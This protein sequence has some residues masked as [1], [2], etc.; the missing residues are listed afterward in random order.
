MDSSELTT[1]IIHYLENDSSKGNWL[2]TEYKK[3]NQTRQEYQSLIPEIDKKEQ[4]SLLAEIKELTIQEDQIILQ[5]KEQII[6]E[7]RVEQDVIIEIRPGTGGIEAGLF[8]RDLY[9]MYCGFAEKKGWRVEIIE[10]RIGEKG[11]FISVFF[12]IKG[13]NAFSWLKNE[14][15]VHRVQRVPET[16]N[17][18]KL[19][20]S[21]ASV[22]ILPPLKDIEIDL[23]P[24]NLKIETCRASGAGG[25][26]V[27]TT[28]SAV[29]VTYTYSTNG[30]TEI[31]TATSQDSRK[32]HE[33]KQKALLVLKKRLWERKQIEKN[34]AIGGLRSVAIGNAE[35]SEK[36]RT[37]NFPA[38]RVTDHRLKISW[39]EKLE[40]IIEGDLEEVC[41]KL[42]DY[43][44]E[45]KLS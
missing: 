23:L 32:Q 15:G 37:Y 24:Q 18:E 4:H 36:I 35:R 33:N 26:H 34:R 17:K 30:K 3:I 44:V 8:T 19:Q 13:K 6:A 25:Q 7:E 39:E 21:T 2:L 20:T 12:A 9:R 45:K 14:A 28:D 38:N 27:N 42:I 29:K 22:V 10:T 16:E 11:N 41:Q 40:F 1:K 31:I 5:I 43:E